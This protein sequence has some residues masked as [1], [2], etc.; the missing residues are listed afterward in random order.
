MEAI[1]YN[2]P[3]IIFSFH[4]FK[5]LKKL[6]YSHHSMAYRTALLFN[7]PLLNHILL[8]EAFLFYV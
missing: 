1:I 4:H 6:S 2:L 5:K 3:Y 8:A 7:P